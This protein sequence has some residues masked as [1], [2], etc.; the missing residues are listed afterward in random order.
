MLY[1]RIGNNVEAENLLLEVVVN[2]PEM[3]DA[4][5]SL[6]LLQA[7]MG[8]YDES[9]TSLQKAVQL[10]PSRSRIWINLF[11]LLDFKNETE[12]AQQALDKCMELEPRSLEFLYTQIEFL[13]KQKKEKEA[14]NIAKII[15]EYYPE[16]PDKKDLLNFIEMNN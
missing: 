7:E 12:K 1:N 15:L 4:F 8:K 14:V 13:L 3:G 6:G 9:I 2:Q 16:L 10:S 11:K 5:Y